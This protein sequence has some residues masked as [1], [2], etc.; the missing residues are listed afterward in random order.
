[1]K[2]L[3]FKLPAVPTPHIWPS[4][5]FEINRAANLA[6]IGALVNAALGHDADNEPESVRDVLFELHSLIYPNASYIQSHEA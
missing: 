2:I 5:V 4:N 3:Q 1:M 6:D